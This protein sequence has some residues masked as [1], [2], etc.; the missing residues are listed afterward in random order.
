E[1]LWFLDQLQGSLEYHIPV[2]L[3]LEG[4]LDIDAL[5]DALKMILS[6]HE[7]LRTIYKQEDGIGYQEILP[8]QDWNIEINTIEDASLLDYKIQDFASLA[9]DLSKDYMFRAALYDLGS[10]R[11]VLAGIFH[12]ISSDGWSD[13]IL[14]EEFVEI[15]QALKTDRSPILKPLPI[16]YADYALWQREHLNGELLEGQLSYWKNQLS[17]VAPLLLPTDYTRPAIQS[18][19]GATLS[20]ELGIEVSNKLERI[21][22]K[23]GS[24]MFMVLLSAFKVLLYRYSGQVDICVGTPI[25]NRTQEELEGLIGFFVN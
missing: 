9:F 14:I 1:R 11:Y 20:F 19:A 10:Q 4:D 13:N 18:T 21:C 7:V 15:Y 5:Q 23:Q 6:R 12:H 8:V 24:T 22:K 16:Q 2:V 3:R 25:A 17:G